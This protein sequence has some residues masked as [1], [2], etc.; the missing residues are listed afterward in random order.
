M[1]DAP[2]ATRVLRS[3]SKPP[4][5]VPAQVPQVGGR[6]T[7]KAKKNAA[8]GFSFS[9]RRICANHPIEG[10][11]SSFRPKDLSDVTEDLAPATKF[12]A[13]RKGLQRARAGVATEQHAP[14]GRGGPSEKIDDAVPP[15]GKRSLAQM[16]VGL[17]K[18]LEEEDGSAED[19]H[20]N[21]PPVTPSAS[22]REQ[23]LDFVEVPTL[24][25][26]WGVS[27]RNLSTAASSAPPTQVSTALAAS[28]VP[29]PPPPPP[30]RAQKPA[31]PARTRS[32]SPT[33]EDVA[34]PR[35]SPRNPALPAGGPILERLDVASTAPPSTTSAPTASTSTAAASAPPPRAAASSSMSSQLPRPRIQDQY[36]NPFARVERPTNPF[37]H[38]AAPRTSRQLRSVFG[39]R[40]PL[41]TQP[42]YDAPPVT[43]ELPLGV[44]DAALQ[45]ANAPPVPPPRATQGSGS[46]LLPINEVV[47]RA[48]KMRA[49][50]DAAPRQPG[51][52]HDEAGRIAIVR[53]RQGPD[54]DVGEPG[55]GDTLGPPD[56]REDPSGSGD[57]DDD[58][59]S[60]TE[61]EER[62]RV[63]YAKKFNPN[64]QTQEEADAE[65]LAVFEAEVGGGKRT[66]KGKGKEKAREESD[67]DEPTSKKQPKKKSKRKDKSK[68][69][70]GTTTDTRDVDSADDESGPSGFTRGPLPT[71]CKD[72]TAQ[73]RAEYDAKLV[74]IA[75][76]YN[77]PLRTIHEL[78]GELTR[79]PRKR[80]LWNVYQTWYAHKGPES[81]PEDMAAADWNKFVRQ[82]FEAEIAQIDPE[83][84]DDIEAQE[85][86][87]AEVLEWHADAMTTELNHL[88]AEH[89]LP[90]GKYVKTLSQLALRAFQD[91]G[92]HIFGF[93]IDED[94]V[95]SIMWGGSPQ[96]AQL[97]AEWPTSISAQLKDYES[98]FRTLSIR[99]RGE[100]AKSQNPVV[101]DWTRRPNE[102]QRDHERRL[103]RQCMASE[104]ISWHPPAAC[105][106]D[107]GDLP[108]GGIAT[109]EWDIAEMA[110]KHQVRVVNWPADFSKAKDL[111]RV[112]WKISAALLGHVMP[113]L[114]NRHPWLAAALKL[115]EEDKSDKESDE[116]SDEEK[117][118]GPRIERW[119]ESERALSL[120]DQGNVPVL[121]TTAD[122]DLIFLK[123][124]K[125]Y[126]KAL[127]K[128]Q[129][130]ER[131]KIAKAQRKKH[132][133]THA[134]GTGRPGAPVAPARSTATRLA[135]TA[136]GGGDSSDDD[137]DTSNQRP[138]PAPRTRL[139]SPESPAPTGDHERPAK[140]RRIHSPSADR[141]RDA[142]EV[143]A[144]PRSKGAVDAQPAVNGQKRKH[145]EVEG[146][147]EAG[148]LREGGEARR[149]AGPWRAGGEAR[150][151]AGS[152]RASGE[153]GVAG[154]SRAGGDVRGAAGPSH[155][156]ADALRIQIGEVAARYEW[157]N[158]QSPTF[159]ISGWRPR[160]ADDVAYDM[161]WA[162]Q[163]LRVRTPGKQWV[164][165]KNAA[166]LMP[167]VPSRIS[168]YH[169][170]LFGDF[171]TSD[172]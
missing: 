37:A 43:H 104:L 33:I 99:A 111:P 116:E 47:D 76:Q 62:R 113:L 117:E 154:P 20:L 39:A 56:D 58:A 151:A 83:V 158:K 72:A 30:P 103:F 144:L 26:V 126:V 4:S 123:D 106:Q 42:L 89:K 163:A 73:A 22:R 48:T 52:V 87:F 57:D 152:S 15:T 10:D 79:Q 108:A 9:P 110:F 160:D 167:L 40:D 159:Y 53:T 157:E 129:T 107:A 142:R 71:A 54:A 31:T 29:P 64:H 59:Y 41:P 36:P 92:I 168:E 138:G 91:L 125:S 112:G 18:L 11:T 114:R 55:T 137:D 74:D 44:V 69:P 28:S 88:K 1:A 136:G 75:K 2:A 67:S 149:V 38:L 169:K 32:R 19:A 17:G 6:A 156:S 109:M 45:A 162:S 95:C 81:K 27:A 86:H 7:S 66:S 85:K 118:E 61:K 161:D 51:L 135:P 49:A 155:A 60:E 153:G 147:G 80:T 96:Y 141:E 102:G 93:I 101:G 82:E 34:E 12:P 25:E 70:V 98:M 84:R 3:S 14:L 164:A 16:R 105:R 21:A 65:D 8:E 97:R 130:T 13:Q 100:E 78:A 128:E 35:F 5:A 148:P 145:V 150:G 23:R 140:R 172:D 143:K 124:A 68:T 134:S 50:A 90:T 122:V 131:K 119:T 77:R 24:Q 127:D 63:T 120:E 146:D 121:T 132:G 170:K 171:F 139:P 115:E 165:P 133:K 94:G 46:R 166:E